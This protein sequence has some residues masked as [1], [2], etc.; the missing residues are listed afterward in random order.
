MVEVFIQPQP[1]VSAAQRGGGEEQREEGR[2][3]KGNNW[4][5]REKQWYF[6]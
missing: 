1:K 2:E 3:R 4:R 5:E 6:C